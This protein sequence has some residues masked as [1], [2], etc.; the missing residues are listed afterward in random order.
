MVVDFQGIDLAE[1][2]TLGEELQTFSCVVKGIIRYPF[3]SAENIEALHIFREF[4]YLLN[5]QESCKTAKNLNFHY[6]ELSPKICRGCP[7]KRWLKMGTIFFL[8]FWNSSSVTLPGTRKHIPPNGKWK[9]ID[10]K[11]PNRRGYVSSQDGNYPSYLDV[12]L[13]LLGSKVGGS[14]GY[15]VITLIYPIYT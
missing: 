6:L 3:L 5:S 15:K 9:I 12:P 7:H 2:F 13:G 14:V 1:W 8:V 11:V 4:Q 10:P